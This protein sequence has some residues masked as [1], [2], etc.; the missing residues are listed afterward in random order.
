MEIIAIILLAIIATSEVTR[1]V[2]T[3]KKPSRKEHFRQKLEGTTKMMWDLEFKIYKTQEIREDVRK[4]Y[5]NTKQR[6]EVLNTRLK[7][8]PEDK[9]KWSDEDKRLEDQKALLTRDQER[10]EQ[11]MKNLDIEIE[12]TKPT[13]D[14][15]DGVNG[16]RQQLDSLRELTEMLRDWIIKQ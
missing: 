2:L 3:H 5:D 15:P 8:L 10:Y 13:N 12:G 14:Y 6:I 7:S 1:L 9:T 4:E 11:Q 16:I